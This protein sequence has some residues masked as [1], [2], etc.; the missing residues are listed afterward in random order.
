[1]TFPIHDF[2]INS[3]ADITE[4]IINGF[5]QLDN[6]VMLAAAAAFYTLAALLLL[7]F[8]LYSRPNQRNSP[9]KIVP[10]KPTLV[11]QKLKK[12]RIFAWEQQKKE[13]LKNFTLSY[14]DRPD[15]A[16]D[17]PTVSSH[18]EVGIASNQGRRPSMEDEELVTE[19]LL[20]TKKGTYVFE[21]YG[22]FDG[23]GGK[24]AA[25]FTKQ[26]L[27]KHL[28]VS[29]FKYC[30]EGLSDEGIYT[31]LKECFRNLDAK[32][33]DEVSGTTATVAMIINDRIWIANVGDSR[34]VLV[35]RNGSAIQASE[36]AKP[37]IER[38]K[39]KIERM[40]GNVTKKRVNGQLAVARA[41]GDKKIVGENKT[42]C[43]SP[44]PKI[45]NYSLNFAH[46][47]LGCDGLF[48]V[49]ST[50]EVG[51]RVKQME[52]KKLNPMEMAKAL[53]NSAIENNSM[54]NV[55]VIVVKNHSGDSCEKILDSFPT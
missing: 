13:G 31:A 23:H 7:G 5:T 16:S 38:Y 27:L 54:D 21:L 30:N 40:G 18:R 33:I 51:N 9:I 1:M 17:K 15:T 49:T 29:L 41:I 34:T 28:T 43:V 52:D 11:H 35:R 32:L 42:C 46:L 36:D 2:W 55:S 26:N 22:I 25:T 6:R 48:D 8:F 10:P 3:P 4:K 45:T 47:I 39:K 24:N 37:K 20:T 14:T 53:V 44:H 50:N 12:N 19:G